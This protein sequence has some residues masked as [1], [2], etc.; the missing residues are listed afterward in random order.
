MDNNGRFIMICEDGT[1]QSRAAMTARGRDGYIWSFDLLNNFADK[2]QG[3]LNPPAPAPHNQPVTSGVWESS[4][5]IDVSNFFGANK[6]IVNVQAHPPTTAPA[7]T[8]ENGQILMMSPNMS[9]SD[10]FEDAK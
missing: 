9:S 4:G 8:T 5:I 2:P 10:P 3:E 1:A 7:D 6:W